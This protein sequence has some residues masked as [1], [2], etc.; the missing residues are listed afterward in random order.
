MIEILKNMAVFDIFSYNGEREMLDLRLNMLSPHVDK[1]IICEAKTTFS[2]KEKPLYFSRDERHFK[3]FWPKMEFHIINEHYTVQERALAWN[4]PNT[5]GA[6]HWKNEF[7]QKER[8]KDALIAYDVHDDDIVY[9]GDVD[10]IWEPSAYL[11]PAKLKLR[12][13]AYYLNNAS[14]EEFWGTVVAKYG[15]LKGKVLNHVR[16]DVG[17]RTDAY[18]GWHFTSMGGYKEVKRKLDDSYTED[19]Y[20]TPE[21]QGHLQEQVE[22]GRD[23]LGRPFFFTFDTTDWPEY[24]KTNPIPY[25]HLCK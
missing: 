21:V 20:N 19:S 23:Y 10:E 7:L 6:D 16:T 18:H 9:I 4:S 25:L 15:Y 14:S 13:F 22:S 24:L 8:M 11:A 5:F 1:F 3:K 12:V 17:L 2:G